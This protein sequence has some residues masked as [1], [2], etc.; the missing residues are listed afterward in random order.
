MRA[1]LWRHWP[2]GAAAVLLLVSIVAA[3]PGA[4][5]FD[6]VRQYSQVLAGRFDDWHPPVMARLWSLLH[7][8]ADGTGPLFALQIAA[9]W[10]GLGTLAQ[11][12]G[13][14]RAAAILAVGASPVLLGWQAVVL[15]DAQLVG[16][17]SCAVGLI[18]WFRL[19]ARPMTW[20]AIA[21]VAL[22]LVY[23]TLLRANAAFSTVPLAVLLFLPAGR[24]FVR[25]AA[26]VAGIV[27]GIVVAIIAAQ[28]VNRHLLGA[29][30]SGIARVEA[31]YDLA[32]IAVRSGEPIYGIDPVAL[33]A[34]HC[35][36]PLFWDPM[37][38]REDCQRP[39]AGIDHMPAGTLYLMLADA[40][41][42]HPVAYATHRLAHLNATLR[43]L[44]SRDWPLAAPPA[45]NEPNTLGL[46]NPPSGALLRW[47]QLAANFI[48]T[49]LGWPFFWVV[50]GIC[51][52]VQ[53]RRIPPGPRRDLAL[54]LLLSALC[55]EASF[56]VLSISSDLRYHLWP[57]LAVALAWALLWDKWR[58]DRRTLLCLAGLCAVLLPA[59]AARLSLPQGPIAYADL[60]N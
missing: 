34:R 44:V 11:A 39:L 30:D 51:G 23:A 31:I 3:W 53:V 25:P 57:M 35:V 45:Y 33:T 50:L 42:A 24:R 49:P 32:G 60:L 16:A 54:A 43:W 4:A 29:R 55:Q 14:R 7:P 52:L 37:Q 10:L 48:D 17:L 28:F 5:M 2:A 47:Q 20:P 6:T 41:A 59:L 18:A 26:I 38:N 15:K 21:A 22:C 58:P 56:T 19:R 46:D 40:A 13:G 27:A 9:Y 1:R 36:K 12:L 8:L